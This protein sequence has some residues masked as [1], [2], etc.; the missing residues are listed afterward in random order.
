M[1]LDLDIIDQMSIIRQEMMN[2]KLCLVLITKFCQELDDLESKNIW[3]FVRTNYKRGEELENM[4][5]T[6]YNSWCMELDDFLN[7]RSE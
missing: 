1:C 6:T 2:I 7:R 5:Y 4:L 3:D